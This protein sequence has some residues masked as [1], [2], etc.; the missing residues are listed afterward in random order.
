MI[1]KKVSF[2]WDGYLDIAK[3]FLQELEEDASDTNENESKVR[4]GISRA[5]YA[6]FNDSRIFLH[7]IGIEPSMFGESSHKKVIQEFKN[8]CNKP[9][10]QQ[11]GKEYKIIFNKLS[12]LKDERTKADYADYLIDEKLYSKDAK[13]N[14]LEKSIRYSEMI[15]KSLSLIESNRDSQA[16]IL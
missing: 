12:L 4:C 6:A 11:F 16:S 5:Y 10:N 3:Q 9:D 7:N 13:K 2:D 8:L 1:S 14:M 15:I